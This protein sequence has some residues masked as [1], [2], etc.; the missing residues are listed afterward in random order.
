[1]TTTQQLMLLE[2][3]LSWGE[4]LKLMTK[5][6]SIADVFL[7]LGA[8]ERIKQRHQ[9]LKE[10]LKE[11]DPYAIK[12]FLSED[13]LC[14]IGGNGD[15]LVCADMYTKVTVDAIIQYRFKI[16]DKCSDEL[17]ICFLNGADHY[18]EE[19]LRMILDE[20]MRVNA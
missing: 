3:N 15:Y 11:K 8:S 18:R 12:R 19:K 10:L 2:K 13:I 1:M 9:E 20:Y 7:P 4:I 14:V 6:I 17:R 16:R 5:I